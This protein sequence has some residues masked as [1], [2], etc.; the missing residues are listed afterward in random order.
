MCS[1]GRV[2]VRILQALNSSKSLP[3]HEVVA[4]KPTS[5]TIRSY[6]VD[7]VAVPQ[8][9]DLEDLDSATCETRHKHCDETENA[10][11]QQPHQ[12]QGHSHVESSAS[13]NDAHDLGAVR[14]VTVASSAIKP[15]P[16]VKINT[17]IINRLLKL[18]V[19]DLSDLGP[20]NRSQPDHFN[21]FDS[22]ILKIVKARNRVKVR[23]QGMESI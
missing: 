3:A 16:A 18:S 14:A 6:S 15:K 4:V 20:I 10:A 2:G 19:T 12:K 21:K 11:R 9:V 22:R 23:H 1:I 8:I 17:N 5:W 13:L 7:K